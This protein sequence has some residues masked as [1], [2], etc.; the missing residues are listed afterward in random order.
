[1]ERIPAQPQ[2]NRRTHQYHQE[3]QQKR[4][5][6]ARVKLRYDGAGKR[7]CDAGHFACWRNGV[8]HAG[9]FTVTMVIL[10]TAYNAVHPFWL[11]THHSSVTVHL[12]TDP[13]LPDRLAAQNPTLVA[14]LCAEWCGTCREYLPK[15]QALAQRLPTH[16][17]VWIDVEDHA[18]LI[19]DDDIEDF[20]TL[21]VQDATGIRFYGSMLPHIAHLEK[22]LATLADSPSTATLAGPDL[23]D[24][25]KHPG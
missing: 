10:R 11:R 9:K 3:G 5:Q 20:P 18:E 1:G 7:L 6:H 12:P 4:K 16:V 15:F 13:V 8:V 23:L 21:L 17:F 14:C 2:Q 24:N 25:L 19:G 22:L